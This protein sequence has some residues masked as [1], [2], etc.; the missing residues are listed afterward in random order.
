MPFLALDPINNEL[1]RLEKVGVVSKIDYSEWASPTVYIKKR[2][3]KIRVCA[4][5]SKGLNK[6]LK[7]HIYPLPNPEEIFAKLKVGNFFKKL[8]LSD[9]YLQLLV[10]EDCSRLLTIDTHRGL[11]KFN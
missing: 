1:N 6:S 3:N 10:D 11:Y 8:D 5:F 9:A 4:D 7:Q 2:N